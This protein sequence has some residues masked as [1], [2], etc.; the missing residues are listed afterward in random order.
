MATA[1]ESLQQ[2]IRS[3]ALHARTSANRALR[4]AGFVSERDRDNLLRYGEEL[5]A[6][7]DSLEKQ[8]DALSDDIKRRPRT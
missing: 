6:E 8:A 1:L 3:R 2:A 5:N 4:L 7:A